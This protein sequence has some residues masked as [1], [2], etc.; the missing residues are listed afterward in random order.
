MKIIVVLV[1]IMIFVFT[2][3]YAIRESKITVKIAGTIWLCFLAL[4]TVLYMRNIEY[5]LLKVLEGV[6]MCLYFVLY[7]HSNYMQRGR[8]EKYIEMSKVQGIS[9]GQK[10]WIIGTNEMYYKEV[11]ETEVEKIY[12]DIKHSC[13]ILKVKHGGI[14]YT[15]MSKVIDSKVF[16]EEAKAQERVQYFQH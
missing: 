15:D 12:K 2:V 7:V 3:L 9:K 13:Y 5:A 6:M 10:V 14:C 4:N 16:T 8:E 1:C 11:V